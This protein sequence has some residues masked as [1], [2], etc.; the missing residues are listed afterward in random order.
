MHVARNALESRGP[1][2]ERELE[3]R[4]DGP[5]PAIVRRL[6]DLVERFVDHECHTAVQ[7]STHVVQ[8]DDVSDRVVGVDQ[9]RVLTPVAI[10]FMKQP[11][12]VDSELIGFVQRITVQTVAPPL[13]ELVECR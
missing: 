4:V 1:F 11:L 12:N 8:L 5:V 2:G 3:R 9:H 6:V 7:D 13:D 10:D